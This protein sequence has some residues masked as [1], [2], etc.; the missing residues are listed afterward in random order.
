MFS[1]CHK[2]DLAAAAARAFISQGEHSPTHLQLLAGDL[3]REDRTRSCQA[4]ATILVRGGGCS[5]IWPL[6]MKHVLC[7]SALSRFR[8]LLCGSFLCKETHNGFQISVE[9]IVF[10]L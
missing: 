4:A 7:L 3:R 6:F 10:Y 8:P 5:S 2:R 9:Q 1:V